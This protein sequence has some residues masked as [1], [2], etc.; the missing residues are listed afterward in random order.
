MVNQKAVLNG[1]RFFQNLIDGFFYVR[2]VI[3]GQIKLEQDLIQI[4]LRDSLIEDIKD[5]RQMFLF[6]VNN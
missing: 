3:L 1:R 4:F 2:H 6:V 5:I